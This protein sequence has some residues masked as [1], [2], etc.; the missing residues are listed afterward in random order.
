MA[1]DMTGRVVLVTGASAG[2][3]KEC[4]VEL[5][6]MGATVVG[7]GR[8][9]QRSD[10]ALAEIRKRSGSKAV[11][12]LLGDFARLDDVRKVAQQFKDRHAR[13]HVLV[14]NAGTVYPAREL[15]P[16]GVEQ[17]F[18]VN[19]LAYF[20]LTHELLPLLQASPPA[21]IVN[22]ASKAHYRGKID[23]T[24]LAHERGWNVE[25]A[26]SRSKLC[27]VL[28]TKELARRLDGTGV[29]ANCLHP[30]VVATDI[31][32]RAWQSRLLGWLIRLTMITPAEGAKTM[33]FLA[34]DPGVQSTSGVYFDTSKP[35]RH[36]PLAD[37]LD[38]ARTLWQK[39][40]EL[41]GVS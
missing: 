17:T 14:N 13:L 18:A 26:Y 38:L 29:T 25:S 23:L 40:A 27:N 36:N 11:E 34:S 15:T 19:H 6:K 35:K 4:C 12:M 32:G 24:D 33:L 37:D 5:A 2:I 41:V 9:P 28:F 39:S 22:V 10:E 20:L 16:Q 30:G 31:W 21:R 3:G 8:N 7:V 1:S